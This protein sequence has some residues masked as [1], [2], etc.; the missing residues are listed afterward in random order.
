MSNIDL[1]LGLESKEDANKVEEN[2][3]KGQLLLSAINDL[4]PNEN[5]NDYIAENIIC[6]DIAELENSSYNIQSFNDGVKSVSRLAGQ[7]TGLVNIGITPS[8]AF[9][10]LIEK[11]ALKETIAHNMEISKLDT[12]N[13]LAIA[14]IN[15]R[16]QVAISKNIEVQQIKGSI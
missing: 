6:L 8:M 1:N 7:I 13:N 5:S 3:I 11:E 16:A 14:E 10:Y 15:S 9:N 4:E 2:N 12:K